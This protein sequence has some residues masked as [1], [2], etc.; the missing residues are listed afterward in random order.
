MPHK[1]LKPPMAIWQQRKLKQMQPSVVKL[2]R[3]KNM[4]CILKLVW[5]VYLPMILGT[6]GFKRILNA[7]GYSL[8]GFKAAYQNEA[9]F[10][11]IKL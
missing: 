1:G 8:A 4:R 5:M 11:Q 10:R 7:T 9:A 2:E 6:T 3:T